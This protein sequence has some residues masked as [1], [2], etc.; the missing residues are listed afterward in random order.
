MF[1]FDD[2]KKLNMN[3][4]ENNNAHPE[5]IWAIKNITE[6]NEFWFICKFFKTK[7]LMLPLD[8][9]RCILKK[10]KQYFWEYIPETILCETQDGE[11]F[12]RQKFVKWKTL[13]STDVS[14][15]PAATIFKIIDLINKYLKYHK[16]QWWIMDIAWYQHY[17]SEPGTF[18][19]KLRNFLK[20]YKNFLNSTNIMIS[21]DW[22]VYMVDVCESTEVR[23]QWRIKNFCAKPFIRMTIHNLKKLLQSK[24]QAEKWKTSNELMNALE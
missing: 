10:K 20:I 24:I 18:E 9:Q 16:E 15:L 8:E 14:D 6:P 19:R 4:C 23:L 13:A 7:E 5:W 1:I 22:N 11:Y 3:T 2:S 17:Q 21:D 12:I